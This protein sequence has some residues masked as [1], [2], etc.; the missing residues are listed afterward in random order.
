VLTAGVD[1][2]AEPKGTALAVIEWGSRATL[3]DLS[4]DVADE[5]IVEAAGRV[6]KL[7][8]D[9]ALGW[10]VEFAAFVRANAGLHVEPA[11][12]DGGM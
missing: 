2:A 3:L 6:A 5:Q 12:F 10:P 4:V 1:L 11:E 8:I 9:C 7:G